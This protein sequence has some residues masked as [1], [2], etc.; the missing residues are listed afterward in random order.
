M[1]QF[2]LTII[3]VSLPVY[4]LWKIVQAFVYR[5]TKD[6]NRPGLISLITSLVLLILWGICPDG[7]VIKQGNDFDD[8]IF[9]FVGRYA[10]YASL[11]MFLISI[12]SGYSGLIKIIRGN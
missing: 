4:A 6:E 10:L 2:I 3:A 11:V 12:L 9:Y 7:N 5:V 1:I 8:L